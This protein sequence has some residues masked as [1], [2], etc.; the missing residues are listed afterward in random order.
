MLGVD[1][2]A[3]KGLEALGVAGVELHLSEQGVTL[4]D[5]V[6]TLVKSPGVPARQR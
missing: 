6:G 3:P 5:G 1:A 4:L 2:G